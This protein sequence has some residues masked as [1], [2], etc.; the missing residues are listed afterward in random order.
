M[1]QQ[2]DLRQSLK[3]SEIERRASNATS[4][5]SEAKEIAIERKAGRVALG[6]V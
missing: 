6:G 4:R 3:H 2:A 5:K 1:L